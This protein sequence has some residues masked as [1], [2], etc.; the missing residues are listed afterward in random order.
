MNTI[1][2]AIVAPL[3]SLAVL[4]ACV[5]K[6]DTNVNAT[7]G[8]GGKAGAAG[9]GGAS[10]GLSGTGGQTTG[11]TGGSLGDASAGASGIGGGPSD[12]GGD[13]GDAI[14]DAAATGCIAELR[15]GQTH[16]CFRR[17]DN[18]IWCWGDN[19][20]GNVGDGT[21]TGTNCGLTPCKPAPVQV[22]ALGTDAE[23]LAA[24][25]GGFSCARKTNGSSW[26][27]GFNG[28]GQLGDGTTGDPGCDGNNSCKASPVEATVLGASAYQV[29]LGGSHVCFLKK[30]STV[31]CWGN[32]AVGQLGVAGQADTLSPVQVTSLGATVSWVTAGP[33]GNCARKSNGT[34]WCWGNNFSVAL[35]LIQS[36][37]VARS[38]EGVS[39]AGQRNAATAG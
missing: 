2:T 13:V 37:R 1:R 24:G 12:A 14:G 4:T 7:G 29:S 22:L 32:N 5:N 35:R 8:A 26:C 21:I 36:A 33:A 31:W 15:A 39:E 30:D 23:Q 38:T 25:H 28:Q 3:V 34:L 10:G 19:R 17:K 11:G 9:S 27:W 16:M 18:T 6:G 20:Y